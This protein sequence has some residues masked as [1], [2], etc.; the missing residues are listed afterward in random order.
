MNCE[1][2]QRG[3]FLESEDFR[4]FGRLFILKSRA[5][6]II[7]AIRVIRGYEMEDRN[8]LARSN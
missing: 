4:G 7:R 8:G 3:G 5:I 6:F 2:L 1:R